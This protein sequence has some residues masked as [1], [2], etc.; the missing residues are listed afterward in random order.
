MKNKLVIYCDMDGVLADFDKE[1]NAINR[2]ENEKGFFFNLEPIAE[3]VNAIKQLIKLGYKIKILSKSPHKSADNDKVKWLEKYLPEISKDNM[4]FARPQERKIDF[5]AELERDFALLLDDYSK[6]IQEW[7]NENGM[8][9]KITK[10][11][12]IPKWFALE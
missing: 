2:Y 10:E 8:A 12:T 5:V 4:I 7:R 6:N 1:Y 3:N 11:R 9:F